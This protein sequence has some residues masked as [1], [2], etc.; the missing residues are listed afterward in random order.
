MTRKAQC[1]Q[2]AVTYYFRSK[3][4]LYLEAFTERLVDHITT[5]SV[6]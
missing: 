3:K 1:N 4:N 5:F 6:R 2:A